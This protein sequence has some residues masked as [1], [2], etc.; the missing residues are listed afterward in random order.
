[1]ANRL[2]TPKEMY[3]YVKSSA[4]DA[5]KKAK[6]KASKKEQEKLAVQFIL[7]LSSAMNSGPMRM[8]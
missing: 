3:D 2:I 8:G 4:L 7:G 6:P 5:A 1:M